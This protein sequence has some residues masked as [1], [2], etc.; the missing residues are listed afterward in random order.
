MIALSIL[1]TG[2]EVRAAGGQGGAG[3]DFEAVRPG[4]VRQ[5]AEGDHVRSGVNHMQVQ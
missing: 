1:S 2:A 5:D 4:H 3:E